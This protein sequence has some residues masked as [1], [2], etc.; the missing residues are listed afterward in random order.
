[1]T[2]AEWLDCMDVNRLMAYVTREGT[3]GDRRKG[4]LFLC[5]CCRR[6]W[7]HLGTRMQYTV[8]SAERFAEGKLS[9]KQMAAARAD[10]Q[11]AVGRFELTEAPAVTAALWTV[12]HG[13]RSLL[14][15]LQ[16]GAQACVE[17]VCEEARDVGAWAAARTT[18]AAL[19][20]DIFGNPFRPVPI[21]PAWLAWHDGLVRQMTQDICARRAFDEMPVL[22]DALEDASCD[23]T[24]LLSHCRGKGDHAI[25]CWVLDRL[26]GKG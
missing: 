13:E 11:R 25:G 10:A 12:Y 26:L 1:M 23:N 5:A 16:A 20:H 19:L 7:D 18:Q 8:E 21:D 9:L 15:W 2:E 3:K 4:R 24:D 14:S 22:A 6:I 17:A